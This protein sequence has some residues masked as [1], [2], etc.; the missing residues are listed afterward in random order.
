MQGVSG[1]LIPT[2]R[3]SAELGSQG[4]DQHGRRNADGEELR[5]RTDSPAAASG[6]N[7]VEARVGGSIAGLEKLPEIGAKHCG[8]WPGL[9]C[10]GA[11]G[12]RWSRELRAA[13]ANGQWLRVWV[14]AAG[15]GIRVQGVRGCV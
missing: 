15:K 3:F 5:R 13:E 10:N 6:R 9:G 14:A 12:P 1:L 2:G 8:V 7:S 11:A 4:S